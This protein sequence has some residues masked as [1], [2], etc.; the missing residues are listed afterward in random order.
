MFQDPNLPPGCT[1][2]MCEPNDPECGNCGHLW[3]EHYDEDS[4]EIPAQPCNRDHIGYDADG[5]WLNSNGE[6][7]HA[8]DAMI[9]NR[10]KEQCD[11]EKF[12]DYEYEPYDERI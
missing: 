3:S 1:N 5:P 9:N 6:V 8:C 7:V 10:T 12:G 4:G 11:C 2:A